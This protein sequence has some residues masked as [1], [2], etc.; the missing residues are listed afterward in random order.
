MGST[1]RGG[2]GDVLNKST[3]VLYNIFFVIFTRWKG[4]GW[5][6]GGW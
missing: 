1:K 4:Q 3:M 6:G 2:R 5:N